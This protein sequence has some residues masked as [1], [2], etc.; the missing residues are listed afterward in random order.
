MSCLTSGQ[1]DLVRSLG[2]SFPV[3]ENDL[4]GIATWGNSAATTKV[5]DAVSF[6][7]SASG[8]GA[9]TDKVFIWAISMGTLPAVR[10]LLANPTKVSALALTVPIV[11]LAYEHDNNI[12][13]FASEIETALGISGTYAGNGSIT[14][15]DPIQQAS[16]IVATGVPIKVWYSSDDAVA[17]TARQQA[18]ITATGCSS[19]NAGAQ[20]HTYAAT[21]TGAIEAFFST[22]A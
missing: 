12:G 6:A 22:Y 18:F 15:I 16:A 20:G 8:L 21:S 5:G 3:V 9:K 1:V 14:A 4:G 2:S 13:G 11:D 17:V 10:Y 7:Q 19:T